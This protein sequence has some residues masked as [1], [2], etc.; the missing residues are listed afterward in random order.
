MHNPEI[1]Q[2]R[3]RIKLGLSR[4]SRRGRPVRSAL[5]FAKEIDAMP[6]MTPMPPM[7]MSWME[8][9]LVSVLTVPLVLMGAA[10]TYVYFF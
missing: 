9:I 1:N 5:S 3:R 6:P 4:R 2:K 8:K 7:T 10:T